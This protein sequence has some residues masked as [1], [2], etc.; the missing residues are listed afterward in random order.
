MDIL[1]TGGAGYI[2]SLLCPMLLEDGHRVTLLDSFMWG[3]KPILHFSTHPDLRIVGEDVRD[4]SVI[5][6]DAP[7]PRLP[8]VTRAI[9]PWSPRSMVPPV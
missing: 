9:F 6:R 7:M 1:V 3:V 5:E 2:G 4:P 8:P